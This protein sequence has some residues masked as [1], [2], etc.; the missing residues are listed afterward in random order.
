MRNLISEGNEMIAEAQDDATRD[1][2]MIAAAQK[3]EHYEIAA[4]G[5]TRTWAS[6]LGNNDVAK[7]LEGILDE[8]K[9]ADQ[10]LTG[11]AESHVNV[12]A[13]EAEEREEDGTAAHGARDRSSNGPP[14]IDNA[15][16]APAG[17]GSKEALEQSIREP[18]AAFAV[19]APRAVT[20]PCESSWSGRGIGTCRTRPGI[21]SNPTAPDVSC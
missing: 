6:L 12:E 15:Y 5:T 20:R 8:E 9:T 3:V 10:K 14:R 2:L 7:L 16:I 1:A 18:V 21:R 17:G 11:I 4:Y 13:A 19:K